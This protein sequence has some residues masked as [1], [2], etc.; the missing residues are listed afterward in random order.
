MLNQQLVGNW[1]LPETVLRQDS[2]VSADSWV[3]TNQFLL[4]AE[5]RRAYKYAMIT[6]ENCAKAAI[7]YMNETPY[8]E[9]AVL[10]LIGEAFMA[11]ADWMAEQKQKEDETKIDI[12]LREMR[13]LKNYL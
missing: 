7:K 9:H 4:T 1:L 11:G 13:T 5:F 3:P 2:Y 10:R 8:R 12:I 6:R